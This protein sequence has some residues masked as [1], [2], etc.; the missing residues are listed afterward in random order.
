VA[1]KGF[2]KFRE[3]MPILSGK[4]ILLLPVYVI[5]ILA[6]TFAVLI[7]FD[8]LPRLLFAT[9]VSQVLLS[10]LPALGVIIM[11]A[12]GF[13]LIYQMWRFRDEYKK[14]YGALSYQEIVPVGFAGV[15]VV[16]VALQVN[17]FVR[18]YSFATSFWATSP[19]RMLAIPID[20][21][22]PSSG[23]AIVFYIRSASAIVSL[24]LGVVTSLRA[25]L[26]FGF[27]YMAVIYL[28]F[29]E[30]S[31]I[32][33]SKIYD[34]LRHPMYAGVIMLNVA[35][36]FS[37]FTVFSIILCLAFILGFWIHVHF[38]EEKELLNRFGTSF[39]E[40]RRKV[41]AFFVSPRKIG[42]FL[43]FLFQA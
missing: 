15:I 43:K 5:V 4:R 21:L 18:F 40:Y 22:F 39:E 30:E 33:N 14:K 41:P 11:E 16:F 8:Y 20:W 2:D 9:G 10:F 24:F 37:T 13:V 38:V 6:L 12:I 26:T 17:Q 25:L 3:K 23:G 34:A 31:K 27:D 29:P 42:T 28:Y 32:Q 1:L 7:L 35:G 19:L 36:T